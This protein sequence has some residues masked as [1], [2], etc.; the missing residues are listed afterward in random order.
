MGSRR[1]MGATG[2]ERAE[3]DRQFSG[4]DDFITRCY[5][6]GGPM[7]TPLRPPAC[8]NH[9]GLGMAV[10]NCSQELK[11][12]HNWTTLS[13]LKWA[14]GH[15]LSALSALQQRHYMHLFE[16]LILLFNNSLRHCLEAL[17]VCLFSSGG[18]AWLQLAWTRVDLA[19]FPRPPTG[20]C[21]YVHLFGQRGTD[22]EN[23]YLKLHW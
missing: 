9:P 8:Q 17:P 16:F 7:W 21:A 10:S 12:R 13:S 15:M 1:W 14:A 22:M 23:I 18:L 6:N 3:P 11:N 19:L 2:Q 4:I 5:L 20:S